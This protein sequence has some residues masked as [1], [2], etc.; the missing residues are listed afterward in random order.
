MLLVHGII[1]DK[2]MKIVIF[3]P[4]PEIITPGFHEW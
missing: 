3:I 4:G 2:L 1:H